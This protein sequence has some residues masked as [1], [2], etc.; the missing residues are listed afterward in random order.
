MK[1][2]LYFVL[3]ALFVLKIFKLLSRRF[4]HLGKMAWLE[5]GT[6]IRTGITCKKIPCQMHYSA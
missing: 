6:T 2:A 1:N 3:K 4:G 5:H